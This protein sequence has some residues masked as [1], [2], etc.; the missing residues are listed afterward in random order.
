[1]QSGTDSPQNYAV[2]CVSASETMLS[3]YIKLLFVKIFHCR[4]S[5]N[6]SHPDYEE[7]LFSGLSN[8]RRVTKDFLFMNNVSKLRVVNPFLVFVDSSGRNPSPEVIELVRNMWG[9]DPVHASL[10]C[11]YLASFVLGLAIGEDDSSV[12]SSAASTTHTPPQGNRLRWATDTPSSVVSP[13]ISGPRSRG[14]GPRGWSGP[15]GG[16]GRGGYRGRGGFAR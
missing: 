9:P 3:V 6:F 5:T 12:A 16:R 15:R 4:S 10:E 8:L 7:D 14:K 13:H 2:P 1:L 11:M